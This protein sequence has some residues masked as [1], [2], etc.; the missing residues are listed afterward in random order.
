MLILRLL[1]GWCLIVAV[2]ALVYDGTK[3]LG[4]GGELIMT[5]LG[6]HWF[7]LNVT[8]L[9]LSQ[10]V[11]E[12]YVSPWLWDPVIITILAA[13]AWVVFAVLGFVLYFLGRRRKKIDVYAN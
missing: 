3:S 11:I 4:S 2:I 13:P 10:A 9:N 7:D 1:G 5:P 12:R 8:S 6:K